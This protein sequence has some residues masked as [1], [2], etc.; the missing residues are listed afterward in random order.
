MKIQSDQIKTKT[1]FTPTYDLYV[2]L[3]NSAAYSG[4]A[5]YLAS[6]TRGS[7]N[8]GKRS[9]YHNLTESKTQY[10]SDT[11]SVLTSIVMILAHK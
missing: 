6:R 1:G 11:Q 9:V 10:E 7:T 4:D 2:V 5:R 3:L 8:A